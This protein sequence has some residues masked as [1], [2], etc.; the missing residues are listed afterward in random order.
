MLLDMVKY[1]V[2]YIF[3]IDDIMILHERSGFYDHW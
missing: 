1:D 3:L 2:L